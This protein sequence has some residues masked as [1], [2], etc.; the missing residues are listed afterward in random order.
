MK[1]III[2]V[3]VLIALSFI[4]CNKANNNTQSTTDFTTLEQQ[5]IN[6]F[7]NSTALP[8]YDS[9][10]SVAAAL[11]TAITNLQA[12]PTDANLQTAQVAWKNIR[13]VWERCEGFL[14]GPVEAY[15]YDPNTDTWPTDHTQMD[16]LL[17]SNN[18]LQVSDIQNLQQNLRG[19]HP[20]EYLIFRDGEYAARTASSFT[21]REFQ[22][23][24]SLSSDILN[25][26]VQPLLQSWISS[27][28][29]YEQ[30]VLTAGTS[31]NQV[32]PTKLSFFL[33]I[34][35]DNGMAG[36]CNEVGEP[37]PDGKMYAPYIN[38]DSTITESPYSDNSLTDFKNNIIGAQ[39]VY[40][41][42]NGGL[43]MKDLVAA[44]NKSLD[45]QIQA[46]FT[47]TINSFSNITERYEQAIFDQRVQ[48]QQTLTQLQTLQSLLAND[49]TNFLKEN[50]KD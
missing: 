34:T 2:P 41:G 12:N 24:V 43:G 48:V 38:K 21:Q 42:L 31:G 47:A 4:T 3:I 13:T 50:V 32:Y 8:Q 45:N 35:G 6:N 49:L 5:V 29:N 18:P 11:N 1:K 9:L 19:Y 36:I 44:K 10:I 14:I 23:L 27:P 15:D 28:V 37:D 26:N 33:D 20:I 40:L 30:A 22:Y 17:A 16:S 46:Q 7:T 39:N 25:N